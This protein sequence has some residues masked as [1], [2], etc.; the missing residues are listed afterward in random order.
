MCHLL[1][2]V[3]RM[4]LLLE[5]KDGPTENHH[6]QTFEPLYSSSA[7]TGFSGIWEATSRAN[8]RMMGAWQISWSQ[9]E[10]RQNRDAQSIVDVIDGRRLAAITAAVHIANQT[11]PGGFTQVGSVPA[12]FILDSRTGRFV[13]AFS[14]A[15]V[16]AVGA[17][18]GG[19]FRGY[20]AS[21]RDYGR[22][23]AAPQ[24]AAEVRDLVVFAC[25]PSL[26]PIANANA[27]ATEVSKAF[28][29]GGMS[30]FLVHN[31]GS[32]DTLRQLLQQQPTHTLLL[33][34]HMDL[35]LGSESDRPTLGFCL[36]DGGLQAITLGALASI[37]GSQGLSNG[38]RLLFLNGCGSEELGREACRVGVPAVVCW[39][40]R[41]ESGAAR[42][43]ST[44][45][46]QAL[47]WRNLQD[48]QAAFTAAKN[49]VLTATRPGRNLSGLPIDVPR[50]ELRDPDRPR[51]GS[52]E[53]SPKAYAAG[54]PVLLTGTSD[55]ITLIE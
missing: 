8:H 16:F 23:L 5:H 10:L 13:L 20:F 22:Y 2:A 27:E 1:A 42:L 48:Y 40:T 15:D 25:S 51:T 36:P 18:S 41:C 43:F 38:L 53:F 34:G 30:K 26:A 46:F 50:Y 19:G 49:A 6:A 33:I 37:L 29:D 52:I 44:A 31:G 17:V 55:H 45:F 39:R 7:M 32:A 21:R 28:T 3:V 54:I 4:M 24:L 47:V 9:G 14:F 11:G 12:Q 35:K